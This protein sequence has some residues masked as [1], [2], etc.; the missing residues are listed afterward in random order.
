MQGNSTLDVNDWEPEDSYFEIMVL[1]IIINNSFRKQL[2]QK[3]YDEI[4]ANVCQHE[5]CLLI[6]ANIVIIKEEMGLMIKLISREEM[7]FFL[8]RDFPQRFKS[9]AARMQK[10]LVAET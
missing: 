7:E 8:R 6:V 1:F 3:K 10:E 4:F 9:L 2:K 5:I